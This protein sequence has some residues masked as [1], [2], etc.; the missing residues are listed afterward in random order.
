MTDLRENFLK[1]IIYIWSLNIYIIY[2]YLSFIQSRD[3]KINKKKIGG[4]YV[5]QRR[6][7]DLEF[8]DSFYS[9]LTFRSLKRDIEHANS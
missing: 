7:E 3:Y 5:V 1:Y 8:I 9:I 4:K 6:N 2:I